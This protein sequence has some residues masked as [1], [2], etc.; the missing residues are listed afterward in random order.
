M[1]KT[2]TLGVAG[3]GLQ[4]A[5]PMSLLGQTATSRLIRDESVHPSIS[6]IGPGLPQIS[7]A[8]LLASEAHWFPLCERRAIEA[9]LTPEYGY[10]TQ[11]R[12]GIRF[13]L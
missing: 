6:N 2:S 8:I 13:S 5:W 12:P 3:R 1:V 11:G 7:E 4:T 10:L 9:R